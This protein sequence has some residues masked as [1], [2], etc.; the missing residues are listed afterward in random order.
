MH[1][2]SQPESEQFQV[3]LVKDQSGLGITIAGYV[4]DKYEGA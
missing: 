4:G 3:T 1:E 2:V